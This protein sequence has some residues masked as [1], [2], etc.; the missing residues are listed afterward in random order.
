MALGG[1]CLFAARRNE[2][3]RSAAKVSGKQQARRRKRRHGNHCVNSTAITD[4]LAAKRNV[5]THGGAAGVADNVA[6]PLY[7]APV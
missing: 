4:F 7:A 5:R 2:R 1:G 3:E 6:L